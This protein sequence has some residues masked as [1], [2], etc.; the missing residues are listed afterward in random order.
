M[1]DFDGIRNYIQKKVREMAKRTVDVSQLDDKTAEFIQST[2]ENDHY[3]FLTKGEK[4]IGVIM[5]PDDDVNLSILVQSV[6]NVIRANKIREKAG[7]V[8]HEE[9]ELG[10][11]L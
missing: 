6:E 5:P 8:S 9:K 3:V 1:A 7:E 2:L 4:I 11:R 10:F